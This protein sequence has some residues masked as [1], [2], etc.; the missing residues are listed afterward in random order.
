MTPREET[1]PDI[2]QIARQHGLTSHDLIGKR[3]IAKIVTARKECYVLLRSRGMTYPQIGRIFNRH[4]TT[5]IDAMPYNHPSGLP[6]TAGASE[7]LI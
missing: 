6:I 4:H 3:R 7:G 5:I 2:G 1:M